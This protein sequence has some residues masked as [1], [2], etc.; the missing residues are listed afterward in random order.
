MFLK[1][2]SSL[3]FLVF[4]HGEQYYFKANINIMW[5]INDA[6]VEKNFG[7]PR[8]PPSPQIRPEQQRITAIRKRSREPGNPKKTRGA[9]RGKQPGNVAVRSRR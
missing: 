6:L 7:I 9:T 4:K 8:L 2:I 3:E 5:I 1:L